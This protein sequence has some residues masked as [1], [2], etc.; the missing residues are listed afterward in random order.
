MRVLRASRNPNVVSFIGGYQDK[1]LVFCGCCHVSKHACLPSLHACTDSLA[2]STLQAHCA[3]SCVRTSMCITQPHTLM[4]ASK[5]SLSIDLHRL[6]ICPC[7]GIHVH[8]SRILLGRRPA[9]GNH[10]RETRGTGLVPKVC[11]QK[12]LSAPCPFQKLLVPN[13]K[14]GNVFA[15]VYLLVLAQLCSHQHPPHL[16]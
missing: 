4:D 3:P 16:L 1:V 2:R 5:H 11:F 7:A 6:F 9:D 15:G 10:E 8:A 13:S 14:F 12:L